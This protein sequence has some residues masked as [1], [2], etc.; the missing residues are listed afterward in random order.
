MRPKGSDPGCGAGLGGRPRGVEMNEMLNPAE[1]A[2]ARQ[3]PESFVCDFFQLLDI[4][5]VT[6]CSWKS[7]PRVELALNGSTDIDLLAERAQPDRI[8]RLLVEQGFKRMVPPAG[9]SYPGIEDWLGFDPASGKL[10]HIHL[11]YRI[12]TGLPGIKEF[13]IPWEKLMLETRVRHSEFDHVWI[14][15]PNLEIVL[16][17]VRLALKYNKLEAFFAGISG[18]D[19]LASAFEELSLLKE[20]VALK[21]VER[22]ASELLDASACQMV[23][24]MVSDDRIDR[25]YLVG[26]FRR[27]MKRVFQR[28]CRYNRS[29]L[30]WRRLGFL[31]NFIKS[32]VYRRLG[33]R[34]KKKQINRG[35]VVITMI[36]ADGSGKSTISKDIAKFL[37]WK[38]DA[39]K[40]YLGE[41][42][43]SLAMQCMVR[44]R[45]FAAWALRP[46]TGGKD[47]GKAKGGSGSSTRA[48]NKEL[49]PIGRLF[50]YLAETERALEWIL[51]V[52][53]RSRTLT[54]IVRERTN[55]A[56]V[57]TDR[58]PQAQIAGYYDGPRYG[59][60]DAVRGLLPRL[61]ART[62]KRFYDRLGAVS[63]D[64]VLRLNV[65][66]EIALRRKPDHAKESILKKVQATPTI[67]FSGAQHVDIDA[68]RP[69]DDVVREARSIV[70][71]SL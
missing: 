34:G 51:I 66:A 67:F 69:L 26:P 43:S 20:T 11:H 36:G 4:H 16:L 47:G 70:W 44:L 61:A 38:L 22:Y 54:R 59:D 21:D 50:R 2:R 9:A 17:L 71:Q 68:T 27:D 55:G 58:F 15:D 53:A 33:L 18:K 49:G 31:F 19:F 57:I 1:R 39:P 14:T 60:P 37:S 40:F 12:L 5:G 41:D 48:G 62:E 35:G 56:I 32:K 3:S 63:P 13:R 24:K 7:N 30:S 29:A 65:T 10:V 64:V 8:E 52:R 25:R 46:V 28:H 23:L 6:F 42:G 45:R